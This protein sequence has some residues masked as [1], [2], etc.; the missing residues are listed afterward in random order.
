MRRWMLPGLL[1]GSACASMGGG[2][3]PEGGE[4]RFDGRDLGRYEAYADRDGNWAVRH[5]RL[6]ASGPAI[7]SVLIR[8]G[9]SLR[10]GWVEAVAARADDGGLVLRFQSPRNYYLLT[11]RD[12]QAP[13]PRGRQ[14]L[15]L[16]HHV[17]G[18]YHQ[19]WAEDVDWPRGSSRTV[20]FE[21]AGRWLAVYLDDQQIGRIQ[22]GIAVN[23]PEP[24]SG[25][26]GVGV[27]HYGA[28]AAWIT[29]FE[30]FRWYS[31]DAER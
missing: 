15:A 12:D 6:I 5:G 7:Q 26:G 24:F 1:L 25:P 10:D 19:L 28:S 3:A 8:S 17:G 21:A 14:N 18:E 23:D 22:P 11:F 20:R 29:Q 2:S 4:D 9:V 30:S 16:Y 27:R 13:P 31:A